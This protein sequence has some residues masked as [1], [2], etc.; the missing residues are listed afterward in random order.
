MEN[1]SLIT[2]AA[3]FWSL[4]ESLTILPAHLAH[5]KDSI[6]KFLMK[7]SSKWEKF[8]LKIIG[9]LNFTVKNFY[10]PLLEKAVNRPLSFLCYA[11][12]IFILTIGIIAGGVI[13]FSFSRQLKQ[14]SQLPQWSILRT[15]LEVTRV[16][17]M[18]LEKSARKLE[19]NLNK[20]F[21]GMNIIQN[22]LST[23]GWQP[24]R[25]KTSQG[26]GN[27]DALYAGSNV[28]EVAFELTPGEDRALVP[29][30]SF[31]DGEK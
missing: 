27:L 10:K 12:G 25:T 29:K 9:G 2:I 30:K 6:I 18:E 7:I 14:T 15:P 17:Y 22:R 11:A 19:E 20:D 4:F 1:F 13:K 3:L 21:P 16:G 24:M 26:P 23:I 28:A 5:S 8:Q 31:E